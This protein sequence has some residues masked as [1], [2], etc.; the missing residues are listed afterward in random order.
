MSLRALVLTLLLAAWAPDPRLS[1]GEVRDLSI[2]V[3]C[4]TKWG[5][6]TRH[7]TAA[8]K[9]EVMAAYKFDVNS[10]PLSN[11][12]GQRVRRAE[13]DHVVP[14]SLGGADTISNLWP[15]CYEPIRKD[16]GDQADGAHK[17]D[18]LEVELSRRVCRAR[19]QALLAE[20]QQRF[21]EDWIA[22]YRSIYGEE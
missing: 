17:K 11:Y 15:Q 3:I 10:C 21:G 4:R 14:R 2:E 1:P 7:V 12:D 22:L 20:Y 13:V 19:S 16:K 5:T 9:A 8:M 18:R 6:D